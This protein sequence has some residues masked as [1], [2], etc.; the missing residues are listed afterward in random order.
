MPSSK[1]AKRTANDVY[2]TQED[3]NKFFKKP[4]DWKPS[5]VQ[6]TTT[7]TTVIQ[8]ITTVVLPPIE[9]K[10]EKPEYPTITKT[11]SKGKCYE[12]NYGDTKPKRK[13]SREERQEAREAARWFVTYDAEVEEDEPEVEWKP[14]VKTGKRIKKKQRVFLS[15]DEYEQF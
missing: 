2:L 4:L 8:Q 7:T 5:Q 9:I 3:I 1:K 11:D 10:K 12:V 13:L 14:E 15:D 6:T